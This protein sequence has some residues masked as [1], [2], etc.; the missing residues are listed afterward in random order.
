LSRPVTGRRLARLG[1]VCLSLG[2]AG[3][4]PA[5]VRENCVSV[6]DGCMICKISVAGK[7]K[8]CS[9]PGIACQP[10]KWRC[11]QQRIIPPKPK[12]KPK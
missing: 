9:S 10:G 12:P 5:E 4:V 1:L 7:L 2:L 6:T 3:F 11:S 8:A